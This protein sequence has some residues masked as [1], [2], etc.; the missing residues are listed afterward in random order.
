[1]CLV[2]SAEKDGSSSDARLD[3]RIGPQTGDCG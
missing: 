3:K 2:N 1:M